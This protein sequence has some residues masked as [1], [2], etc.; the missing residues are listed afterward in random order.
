MKILI[1]IDKKLAIINGFN[2]DS[3]T[4]ELAFDPAHLTDLERKYLAAEL[5]SDGYKCLDSFK[6]ADNTFQSLKDALAII[7]NKQLEKNQKQRDYKAKETAKSDKLNLAFLADPDSF[8]INRNSEIHC[9][10]DGVPKFECE[11]YVFVTHRFNF[12]QYSR[13][14]YRMY[15]STKNIAEKVKK[16]LEERNSLLQIEQ[17]K[18][19]PALLVKYQEKIAL[20]EKEKS[21]YDA[22]YARLDKTLAAKDKAGYAES[23]EITLAISKIIIEDAGFDFV[24]VKNENVLDKLTDDEYVFLD[25]FGKANKEIDFKAAEIYHYREAEHNEIGD[26]DNEIKVLD[27]RGIVITIEKAGIEAETFLSFTDS[28]NE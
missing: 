26:S 13:D 19:V 18:H 6:I 27:G 1:N 9:G 2:V 11:G 20:I 28:D 21:D 12:K 23:Y 7:I 5:Q 15:E 14:S 4:A 10:K 3:S 17:K 8:L 22:L 24:H 25:N 16:V